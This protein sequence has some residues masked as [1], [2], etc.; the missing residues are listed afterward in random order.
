MVNGPVNHR[1]SVRLSLGVALVGASLAMTPAGLRL[2]SGPPNPAA[3]ASRPAVAPL[4]SARLATLLRQGVKTRGVPSDLVPPLGRARSDWPRVFRD[5]CVLKREQVANKAGCVFGDRKSPVTVVLFGDSHAA[6]WFPAMEAVSR[7]Q[8][9]RLMFMG[10][11]G[12]PIADV[13]VRNHD[14]SP[15]ANCVTW[16]HNSERGIAKLRPALVVIASSEYRAWPVPGVPTGYGNT[17]LSGLVAT[18]KTLRRAA[19]H[20]VFIT[21]VPR[22]K[23]PATDCISAHKSDVFPCTVARA[24]AFPWP[25]ARELKLAKAQAVVG[26]NP[27]SWFCTPDRCPVVVDNLLLLHDNQHVTPEWSVFLAPVL[28]ARLVQAMR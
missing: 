22:L 11:V 2:A 4:T 26:I 12:C 19:D 10:K 8:H 21:E 17:W 25:T 24:A 7:Q 15:Y 9:W 16:R 6:S 14:Q 5:G 27:A 20:V 18:F 23:D 1:F 3:A 13:M 28:G